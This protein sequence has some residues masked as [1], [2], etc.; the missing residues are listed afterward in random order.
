MFI[1]IC[2]YVE[3]RQRRWQKFRYWWKK[4]KLI[5]ISK[6]N[7]FNI[8]QRNMSKNVKNDEKRPGLD[9]KAQTSLKKWKSNFSW[10]LFGTIW[11]YVKIDGK[12]KSQCL[13]IF[14]K[15]MELCWKT[16]KMM[17]IEDD[18]FGILSKDIE[19]CWKTWEMIKKSGI[20]AK[21]IKM[22]EKLKMYVLKF[23]RKI[24]KY[25]KKFEK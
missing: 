17:E 3:K 13:T 11:N 10:E 8:F 24:W 5:K 15:N 22:Y 19:I 12:K 20:L 7:F 14:Q 4:S 23:L 25:V 9:A 1:K 6:I 18:F 21:T 2:N 16:T